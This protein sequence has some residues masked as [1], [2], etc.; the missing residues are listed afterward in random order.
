MTVIASHIFASAQL[1]IDLTLGPTRWPSYRTRFVRSQKKSTGLVMGP[2]LH[3]S[4]NRDHFMSVELLD[5]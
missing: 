5:E 2:H 1:L 3:S 4:L